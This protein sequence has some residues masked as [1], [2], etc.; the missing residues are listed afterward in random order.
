L[1]PVVLALPLSFVST[2][3]FEETFRLFALAGMFAFVSTTAWRG[4]F[5][6]LVVAL[7]F[8]LLLLAV[9]F[10]L[11]VVAQPVRAA[12]TARTNAS[13]KLRR[14]PIAPLLVSTVFRLSFYR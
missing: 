2:P 12:A 10:A 5:P 8:L 13:A 9:L 6:A 11:S 1:I 3:V 4:G 14:I 7:E